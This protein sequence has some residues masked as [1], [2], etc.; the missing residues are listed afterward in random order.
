MIGICETWLKKNDKF[1]LQ[2]YQVIRK[3]WLGQIGGGLAFC[4]RNDIQFR[5]INLTDN[6]KDRLETIG[7]KINYKING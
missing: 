1:T 6:Y 3:D 5:T 7:L 4:I 2:N